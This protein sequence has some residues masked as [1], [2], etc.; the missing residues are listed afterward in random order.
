[1]GREE[2]DRGA[3]E[4]ENERRERERE[5]ER[6]RERKGERNWRESLGGF[7]KRGKGVRWGEGER[8]RER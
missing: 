2:R 8:E 7:F 3:W 4:R 6:G 1:M 5:G